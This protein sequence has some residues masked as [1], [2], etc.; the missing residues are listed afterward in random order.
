MN[1]EEIKAY[2]K[3]NQKVKKISDWIPRRWPRKWKIDSNSLSLREAEVESDT[4]NITNIQTN[5]V[6][7]V[8]SKVNI[9]EW[10]K[11]NAPLTL[12][13][14]CREYW[15]HHQTYY[16]RLKK[17]PKIA[18]KLSIM[19]Q[20]NRE[21]LKTVSEDNLEK[22][23]TW[24]MSTLTEKDQVDYSLKFLERTDKAYNP[25]IEIEK[26]EL[27]INITTSWKE[28]KNE[29]LKLFGWINEEI[30]EAEIIE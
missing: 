18:E 28:L 19:R 7:K 8:T 4:L 10:V 6:K 15:I 21:F 12:I 2:N 29:L 14:A 23:I 25:K 27:K 5:W 24:K 16:N 20:N 22:A 3:A 9:A 13:Q 26:K 1:K 17:F 11:A 30:Q